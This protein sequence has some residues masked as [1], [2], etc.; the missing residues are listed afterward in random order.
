MKG[1]GMRGRRGGRRDIGGGWG[2]GLGGEVSNCDVL[3]NKHIT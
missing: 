1:G 3:Y 2:G